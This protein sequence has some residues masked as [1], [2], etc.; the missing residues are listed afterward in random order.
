MS[1]PMGTFEQPGPN[2]GSLYYDEAEAALQKVEIGVDESTKVAFIRQD[3]G[4]VGDSETYSTGYWQELDRCRLTVQ[5][6]LDNV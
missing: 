6:G 4:R 3:A 2:G 5:N 1:Q